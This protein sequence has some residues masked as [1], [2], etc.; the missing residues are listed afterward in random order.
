MNALQQW[1][2][3]EGEPVC[4]IYGT[5]LHFEDFHFGENTSFY[6]CTTNSRYLKIIEWKSVDGTL[7][8]RPVFHGMVGREMLVH[9]F[10][11]ITKMMI[12]NFTGNVTVESLQFRIQKKHGVTR[13]PI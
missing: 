1:K 6:R 3:H 12:T 7:P 13:T 4:A 10:D 8:Y 9:Y 5:R 2:Y 11:T